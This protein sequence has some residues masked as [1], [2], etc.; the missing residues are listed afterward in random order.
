MTHPEAVFALALGLGV[1]GQ[2]IAAHLRTPSIVVLLAIGLLVGPEAL[3]WIEPRALG[4][5]LL[6]LVSLSVAVIL[7]EGALNLDLR[8]LRREG[9]AIRALITTGAL[10]TWLGAAL[11]ARAI[12]GWPWPLAALFGA[13]VIVTGPTVIGPLVRTLRL[14]PSVATVLEAEG[15]LIDPVGAILA[16]LTLEAV[17]A[18][19]AGSLAA[20]AFGLVPRLAFGAAAGAAAGW[21]LARALRAP[22]VVPQGLDGLVVLGGVLALFALCNA[23]LSESGILAVVAAGV[24]LA[25]APTRLPDGLREFKGYLTEALIGLLFVLLAADVGFGA[26][27]ALGLPG[28]ATVA[29]LAFVVRPLDVFASTLGSAL[30]L[31]ERAYVAWLGPRG[32]VA[33]AIASFGAAS[34]DAHGQPGGEALRALVFLTIALSVVVLGGLGGLVARLLGVRAPEPDAILLLGADQ[35]GRALARE[36]DAGGRRVVFLDSNPEHCRLAEEDGWPVVFGNALQES[37]LARARPEQAG[38]V[39]AATSNE[40]VNSLFVREAQDQFR[41]PRAYVAREGL[42]TGVPREALER[43]GIRTLFDGP[44]DLERW[45]VRFRHGLAAVERFC[46]DGAPETPA[47]GATA[48]AGDPF[49][50][51]AVRRDARVEPMHE[52]FEP[53]PG[54]EA[55]VAL[56]AEHRDEARAALAARGW[57]ALEPNHGATVQ[58]CARQTP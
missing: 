3:G 52:D 46:F 7:F 18:P 56:D 23:V 35:V 27:L 8:R 58:N 1:L 26:M 55:A 4:D 38:A 12:L 22:G 33:A 29:A 39:V 19:D 34:L 13:M 41:I 44:K 42:R 32:I 31:R 11:A 36:L 47:A 6:A 10:V 40:R 45:N 17:L 2:T 25:N 5:G 57:K 51:L 28:L 43:Q 37:T 21:L 30:S 49:L 16:A 48:P 20:T 9:R 54:D 24:A 50:V 53:R 14:R 15:V